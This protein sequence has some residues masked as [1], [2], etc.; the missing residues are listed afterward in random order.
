MKTLFYY[1]YLFNKKIIKDDEPFA[2]TV[3]TL[4]LSQ[5]FIVT[6]FLNL[7][8]THFYCF[9][10]SKWPMIFVQFIILIINYLYFNKSGKSRE[11]VKQKPLFF[12]SHRL[13]VIL[14][15][16]FFLISFSL[17]TFGAIYIKNLLDINCR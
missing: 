7:F 11:I 4:S 1:Y 6:F 10:L 3:F 5:G 2:T 9:S 13:S 12:S 17:L 16:L 14:T 8:F 15:M